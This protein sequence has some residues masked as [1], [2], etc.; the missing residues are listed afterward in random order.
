MNIDEI[1]KQTE[2][3]D[4]HKRNSFSVENLTNASVVIR[5]SDEKLVIDPWFKD[6]IYDGTWHNF[7]RLNE[8]Q[9]LNALS[10]VD[11]CMYTHLHKDHFCIDTAKKYFKPS[12]KFLIPKVWGW[13][14]IQGLLNKNGFP[15]THVLEC[16][17]D[18]FDTKN[19]QI[20]TVPP[21]NV[22]G[23]EAQT[24]NEMSI[25]SG[26][27]LVHKENKVKC[28]FLADDN[29]YSDI[30]VNENIEV[31][32]NP[33][34]IAFAYSGFA[35]D[36]PFNFN[37]SDA[38]MIK[39][40]TEQ[41]NKRFAM[42]V[43]NLQAI[44]PKCI[45]PY[46][47]EFVATGNHA[48][49]WLQILGE[50]WTSNKNFVAEKYASEL[51]VEGIALYPGDYVCYDENG[52][53]TDYIKPFSDVGPY[54]MKAL[55]SYADDYLKN[56]GTSKKNIGR[57]DEVTPTI[58]EKLKLASINY[59]NAIEKH[60]LSPLQNLIICINKNHSFA[61]DC[62]GNFVDDSM[63][64]DEKPFLKLNIDQEFL[65]RMLD[66]SLHWDD[67]CLSLKLSWHR[68]PNIFCSDTLNA[69]NYL[70]L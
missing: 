7:P 14:V 3:S 40:C 38:E 12:T 24:E 30:R 53:K 61:I 50:I 29:M 16:S 19:F 42:Q 68:A 70:K 18:V 59:K 1:N 43:K 8:D 6:G 36:Y 67:A 45:M 57:S 27:C 2:A 4:K 28:V 63:Q 23:L 69:I 5:A 20:M 44:N 17:K 10:E 56:S 41:E 60:N 13:Q 11:V 37:F 34:L 51:G 47:S 22:T 15:L 25:D 52:N 54:S 64:E 33:D 46:S 55:L 66:G 39:I 65:E 62:E 32:K 9:K 21:L 31:L 35:S 26:F 49:K 48:K 58:V